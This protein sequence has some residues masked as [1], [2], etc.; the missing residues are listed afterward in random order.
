VSK[1]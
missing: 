1:A